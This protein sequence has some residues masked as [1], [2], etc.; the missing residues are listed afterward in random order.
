M[1]KKGFQN[2]TG[3][4]Q[5]GVL[6]GLNGLLNASHQILL[7]LL[8]FM[9]KSQHEASI[10]LDLSHNTFLVVKQQYTQNNGSLVGNLQPLGLGHNFLFV[11]DLQGGLGFNSQNQLGFDEFFKDVQSLTFS[12]LDIVINSKSFDSLR[13]TFNLS[14]FDSLLTDIDGPVVIVVVILLIAAIRG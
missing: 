6:E 14:G 2:A 13:K 12:F 8:V 3:L 4:S 9:A 10:G 5:Q 7:G 1:I 11:L